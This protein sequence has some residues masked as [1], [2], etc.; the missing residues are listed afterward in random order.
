MAGGFPLRT[1]VELDLDGWTDVTS[2]VYARDPISI[3]RGR[4]GDASS[5]D[6]ANCRFTLDNRDDA[7]SMRN[8]R[9]PY[10]GLLRR[11]VPVRVSLPAEQTALVVRYN[12]PVLTNL[13][14]VT[15]P[16]RAEFT[17][18]E[19]FDI[20]VD[21]DAEHWS[22]GTFAAKYAAVDGQ[23]EWVFGLTDNGRLYVMWAPEGTASRWSVRTVRLDDYQSPG[24]RAVR[25]VVD[26]G[27]VSGRAAATFYTAESLAGPWTEFYA[28]EGTE[29]K[30]FFPGPAQVEIG[31]CA[32]IQGGGVPGR[33]L[34]VEVR[35]DGV[36]VM[37]PD[38][39]AQA[40][41]T[42]E[43]VD[44]QGNVWTVGA[45]AE[46]TDR[47]YRFFGEISQWPQ[48]RDVSGRDRTVQVTAYGIRRRL[49]MNAPPL[50]SVMVREFSSP[51]RADVVAYWPME[52]EP[53]STAIAS[54]LPGHA[55]MTIVG[56]PKLG[57]YSAWPSSRPLPV[58]MS[59]CFRGKV[60]RYDDS[61]GEI[62]VRWFASVHANPSSSTGLFQLRTSTA[63]WLV[64]LRE[65]GDIRVRAWTLDGET[66]LYS[67]PWY[68]IWQG[69]PGLVRY[70]YVYFNF[71]LRQQGNAV[72]YQIDIIDFQAD[73]IFRQPIP[74]VLYETA[75]VTAVRRLG[76]A[77]SV[78]V[79]RNQGLGDI[80]IGHLAIANKWDAFAQTGGAL[81][82]WNGESAE[83]RLVRLS[84]EDGIPIR[85]NNG[86]DTASAVN[87]HRL[88]DQT[89][90]SWLELVERVELSD[91]G[92]LVE[93]RD[94][95]GFVYRNRHSLTNQVPRLTLDYG[96]GEIAGDLH[97][98]DDDKAIVNDVRVKRS[99]G[100]S[101]SAEDTESALSVLPPPFGVG[102]YSTEVEISAQSDEWLPSQASFRLRRGTVDEP[103][104]PTLSVDL[105][106]P[107]ISDEQA[108]RVRRLDI[109]DRVEILNA[110]AWTEGTGQIV[111][112]Y[113]E[114]LDVM[115]HRFTFSLT[116]ASPWVAA[117]VDADRYDTAGSVVE[118]PAA[119][120]L[121]APE[122]VDVSE[123]YWNADEVPV[124]VSA[125]ALVVACLVWNTLADVT[126]P[127]GWTEH[128][129][130]TGSSSTAAVFS[131]PGDVADSTFVFSE[132]S[133]CSV[134]SL[135]YSPA[136]VAAVLG[137]V[138]GDSDA[139]REAPAV[140]VPVGPAR[141]VRFYWEK[142]STNTGWT[143]D[144]PGAT[145]RGM[146]LGIGGGAVSAFVTDEVVPAGATDSATA[147]AD[148]AS[149]QGGGISLVLVS[150]EEPG[151]PDDA[152]TETTTAFDVRTTV[153]PRWT[154]D[155]AEFPL[156]VM[157]GGERMRV[158]SITGTGD[159]QT[160]HVVRG[161][162]GIVKPHAA[163]TD[164]R[165]A[166]PAVVTL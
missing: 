12:N 98:V 118:A 151:E 71:A 133:K 49:E 19:T 163:G 20:R 149:G 61:T 136:A 165:L 73:Q 138:D 9:S 124:P 78:A 106:S 121:E 127:A 21:M 6:P 59:G 147:T 126:V 96:S 82:T 48:S 119:P 79:G 87:G 128:E 43:F 45:D 154:T 25:V 24:R 144:D 2:R 116:P 23:R 91:M 63:S 58:M 50:D 97:P 74:R 166:D 41:G 60:P 75:T 65:N 104:Y 158:T 36:L 143:A 16:S 160:F 81:N 162:N 77:T 120:E 70:G 114:E 134:V 155:P 27:T 38:F 107:R 34:G 32:G 142:S 83:E 117:V 3:S 14:R 40:P 52:D 141:L 84:R 67:S 18:G 140:A 161:V 64:D 10:Y 54:G 132:T 164:V 156:D 26:T 92:M 130:V 46:I 55:P 95:L 37:S 62:A 17:V 115:A 100:G 86:G 68:P 8:P 80:T 102:R 135:G 157:V 101:Y 145:P 129:R 57:E 139:T 76:R 99:D 109:G 30:P 47:D 111:T 103:R 150:T 5:T 31:D 112:G 4:S 85:I 72:F 42:S 51:R 125:G 131:A 152:V 7:F 88:G 13:S 39:S 28:W 53:G 153:G 1:R 56:A 22:N 29:P 110:D 94:E 93:P 90:D 159:V 11:N 146:Q 89:A 113:T 35:A 105:H 123:T 122:F 15:T 66:Q 44:A 33:V 137:S 108:R 148:T 69:P